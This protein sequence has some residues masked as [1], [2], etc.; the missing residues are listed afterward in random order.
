MGRIGLTSIDIPN[1]VIKIWDYAFGNCTDLKQVTIP[2]SVVHLG[3]GAFSGCTGMNDIYTHIIHPENIRIMAKVFE[4]VPM[5]TC[6]VHVPVGTLEIYRT[7]H[8]WQYFAHIY[9]HNFDCPSDVN[10]DGEVNIA[11]IN[12]VIDAIMQQDG[13][14]RSLQDVNLDGEVNIADVNAIINSILG[15]Q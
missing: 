12:S 10:V 9:E 11:D 7:T 2:E 6:R 8:P 14:Y 3:I 1:S 15:S 5:S 13:D 4:N